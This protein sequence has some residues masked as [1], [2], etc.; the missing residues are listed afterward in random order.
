M[1]KKIYGPILTAILIMTGVTLSA[2]DSPFKFGMKEGVNL[3]YLSIDRNGIPDNNTKLGSNIGVAVTCTLSELLSLQSGLAVANKGTKIEGKAP[4]GFSE[5]LLYPGR[6]ASLTSQQWYLQVPVLLGY[7][8][9]VS[10]E[11]K[12]LVN[13]GSLFCLGI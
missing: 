7:G 8:I 10:S 12:I 2:Q 13:L 11:T 3:S 6:D 9:R 5:S 4:I 1:I